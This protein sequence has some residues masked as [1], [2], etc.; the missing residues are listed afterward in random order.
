[1]SPNLWG[2]GMGWDE[3]GAWR[4]PAERLQKLRQEELTSGLVYGWRRGLRCGS[5]GCG[6]AGRRR[7]ARA[8]GR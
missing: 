5:G 8:A 6:A 4:G 2:D 3:V 1:M 7:F